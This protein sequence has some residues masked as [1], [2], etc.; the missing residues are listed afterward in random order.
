MFFFP[1]YSINRIHFIIEIVHQFLFSHTIDMYAENREVDRTFL[2]AAFLVNVILIRFMGYHCSDS[3]RWSQV[4]VQRVRQFRLACPLQYLQV[5]EEIL[6]N[7]R[8]T[9][10]QPPLVFFS[11]SYE[12]NILLLNPIHT[13]TLTKSSWGVNFV[14]SPVEV[15]I[16][17][18][19]DRILIFYTRYEKRHNSKPGRAH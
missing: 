3:L 11:D 14:T 7:Q 8:L 18:L 16:H 4:Q 9:V 19:N 15:Y 2:T 12:S 10:F 1:S 5:D 6:L 17:K 13:P